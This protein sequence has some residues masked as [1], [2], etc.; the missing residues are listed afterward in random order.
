MKLQLGMFNTDARPVAQSDVAHMLGG[1]SRWKAETADEAAEGPL[2]MIYR[3]DQITAEEEREIQ[4]LRLGEMLLT[5][6]GRLD[7]RKEI[8]A[9][10]GA[11]HLPRVPDPVLVARGYARLGEAIFSRLIGEFALALWCGK[12][13]T[14]RFVRSACGSR[15]LFYAFAGKSLLWSSD[16]AHLV[17]ISGAELKINENYIVEHL[18]GQPD[19]RHSPLASVHVVPPNAMLGFEN[20]GFAPPAQ[21][22]DPAAIRPLR[23]KSDYE[24]EEHCRELLAEAVRAKLRSRHTVFSELSGGLDSSSVVVMADHVLAQ[25]NQ[26]AAHLQT[27][28]C[29]FEESDSCDEQYFMKAVEEQRGIRTVRISEKQQ[30]ISSGLREINFTGIPNPLHCA[31]GRFQAYT[32]A[33]KARG[34][35]L[36]LTGAGGDHL[37]WSAVDA[38][39][40]IAD[41][42]YRGQ[43]LQMHRSCQTWSRTMGVPYMQLLCGQALPRAF[44]AMR[45]STPRPEIPPLPEWLPGQHRKA[46][47][48]RM[49]S[50]ENRAALL[51]SARTQL[52]EL[53]SL[54]NMTSAGYTSEYRDV[55]VSHPFLYRPL[56][57]FC[58][59]VPPDQFLRNGEGRSLMRRALSGLL[60]PRILTRKSKGAIN[61]A[62]SRALQKDWELMDDVSQWQLCQRGF[63]DPRILQEH[64]TKLMLGIDPPGSH[65]VRILSAER[66]LRSLEIAHQEQPEYSLCYAS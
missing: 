26:P 52:R 40:L 33:M 44:A 60:P 37:F 15:P 51:P 48:A 30:Q 38:A 35:R 47:F 1:Y 50:S 64:L 20:H 25:Q 23:Y 8:A 11:A 63:A 3:G 49:V 18:V 34:A 4:P 27:I 36:L 57:E 65:V 10:G 13:R 66:W 32:S 43:F 45:S 12:T 46:Y 39:P 28:S 61:E 29:V 62:F 54:F 9:L 14:L 5:W 58:L 2:L 17:R 19:S 31:S 42:I 41:Y 21:L 24:Y 59:A 16:F 55:Y 7:N 56:V 6:D 53:R 22:W